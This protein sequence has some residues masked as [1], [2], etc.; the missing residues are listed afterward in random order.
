MGRGPDSHIETRQCAKTSTGCRI[1]LRY[2]PGMSLPPLN[3]PTAIAASLPLLVVLYLMIGRNWGGSKA[4]PV[5]WLTA[6]VIT[7][8]VF[9]GGLDLLLVALGRSLLLA[10]FVLY[11]IWMALLLYQVVNE[12]GA[13]EVIG[14]ELP[15]LAVDKPAQALLL[16][17]VFGSFLQ[18][19]SGFGVPAAVVAPLLFGLGFAANSAVV[20]AL[21]GHAW[22]VTFGSL[23]S[24]FF[25][26][27][28]ATAVAGD[29][30]EGPS[31]ALLGVAC[32]LCGLAVLWETGHREAV[33][34]RWTTLLVVGLAMAG[35]QYLLAAAGLWSLAAFGAGLVGL[36]VILI[37][38]RLGLLDPVA[39]RRTLGRHPRSRNNAPSPDNSSADIITDML[40]SSSQIDDNLSLGEAATT[41]AGSL[42]RAL[43]PYGLLTLIIILGQ[44]VFD[45][46]L[47]VIELNLAFPEV[48]TS[49]GWLT[50]AGSGR[51]TSL[52]GHAGALLLY[53]S[54]LSYLWFR[55]RGTF[56]AGSR[57]SFWAIVGRT[58]RGS[59][60]STVGIVTLVAMA[61]TMQLAGM[62]QLLAQ[63]LSAG[64][65]PIFPFLSPFI[66]ALGAFMTGSNTNSN[67][68]FGQLQ[69]DTATALSLSIVLIL[70]AQTAGGAIGSLFA[71]AKVIVGTSTVEGAE[72]SK[73][74]GRAVAYGLGIVAILGI[75][76][77]LLV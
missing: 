46:P 23:G 65:G 73:V 41:D 63:G 36:A 55:W 32:L 10:F 48:S 58:A 66:G 34:R 21:V 37:D 8:V 45:R 4:G 14:R 68:V 49:F 54:V 40:G 59:I 43:L 71:P 24:S 2:T 52:L 3:L 76:T 51:S 75:I 62:T 26:L 69:L 13:V 9:G 42:A 33:R 56:Q 22:A 60:K 15:G 25:S 70:A 57:Y 50:P 19:A 28:A 64:T 27:M 1:Q 17:W 6:I 74:L 77:L 20:I 39:W 61:V 30:L 67:V 38:L 7:V 11:I 72:D 5:G 31:A 47:S 53:T 16:G 18:G 44:L 35:S 29:L 12:A